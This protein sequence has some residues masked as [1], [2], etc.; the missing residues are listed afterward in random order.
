MIEQIKSIF[1]QIGQGLSAQHMGDMS[2][3]VE[4]IL[5]RSQN[6]RLTVGQRRIIL[7]ASTNPL[8]P[9][10]D[11]VVDLAEQT[12]S[13]I[14]VLY[15]APE[16]ETKNTYHSLLNRLGDLPFDFQITRLKGNL[17]EEIAA[18]N[19]QREDIISV[20]CSS[21]EPFTKD[22]SSAPKTLKPAL[23]F[24]FPTILFI[25]SNLLA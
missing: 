21:A 18:Y 22:L 9:A 6:S 11:F 14:E 25:G 2:A 19:T 13:M 24:T 4:Q 7:I 3:T 8:S 10:F 17:Y 12:G 1:Q 15:I 16:D 20:I 23:R 5:Q